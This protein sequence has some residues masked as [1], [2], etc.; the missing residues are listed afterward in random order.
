MINDFEE[1]IEVTK[2]VNQNKPEKWQVANEQF[3]KNRGLLHSLYQTGANATTA[4]IKFSAS[5]NRLTSNQAEEMEEDATKAYWNS[6][7]PI[8]RYQLCKKAGVEKHYINSDFNS[9]KNT[10]MYILLRQKVINA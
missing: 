2:M 8:D 4:W 10:T 5:V 1:W 7:K 3:Q 9:I 6:L